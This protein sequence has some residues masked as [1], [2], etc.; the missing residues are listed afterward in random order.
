MKSLFKRILLGLAALVFILPPAMAKVT[1]EDVYKADEAQRAQDLAEFEQY[2]RDYSY[3]LEPA[4][5]SGASSQVVE[6]ST[7]GETTSVITKTLKPTNGWVCALSK[8]SGYYGR[9][10]KGTDAHVYQSG[11]YWKLTSG[12]ASCGGCAV[13]AKAVCW[14]VG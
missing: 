1:L 10:L 13:S 4:Y 5:G 14:E 6:F 2:K 11:G 3:P 8:V 12:R 9:G 7:G